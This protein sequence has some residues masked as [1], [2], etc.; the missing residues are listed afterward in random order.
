M[1]R[2]TQHMTNS[3]LLTT[4]IRHR[5]QVIEAQVIKS[6]AMDRGTHGHR[7]GGLEKH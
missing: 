4:Q 5:D 6:T 7:T 3:L 1:G 2:V